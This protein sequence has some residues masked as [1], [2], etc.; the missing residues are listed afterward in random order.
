MC[1]IIY[2]V[3][4]TFDFKQYLVEIFQLIQEKKM[5]TIQL[6]A[7]EIGDIQKALSCQAAQDNVV[8]RGIKENAISDEWML[9]EGERAS[10]GLGNRAGRMIDLME[11]LDDAAEDK[12]DSI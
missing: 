8:Q 11:K 12:N 3:A 5:K 4:E 1:D 9:S 6:T 10:V 2:K 7:S